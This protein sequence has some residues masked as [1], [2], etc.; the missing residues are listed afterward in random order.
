MRDIRMI[1]AIAV[2]IDGTLTDKNRVLC[3]ASLQAVRQLNVPLVLAT[4][5]THCFT[6]TMAIVLG[7]PFLFIAENGGVVCRS[8]GEMEILADLQICESAY[9]ELSK[10]FQ[11][12]RH[13]SRYRFTDIT[14]KRNFDVEAAARYIMERGIPVELIDTAF[15][16]HIKDI[17]VDKGT[18]LQ[19]I[20][21]RMGIPLKEFAAVGD[22]SSDYPMF[23]LAGFK[24]SVGNASPDLK[25]VSD[26][27][28]KAEYGEGFAE[29]AKYL[30]DKKM[31]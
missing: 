14:L 4:G 27:V 17:S 13:D 3:P 29:I 31:V 6:R 11:L 24:A 21:R 26:Y 30:V 25:A 16:V 28:A 5:N 18:G 1:R 9:L 7:T 19:L 2:D 10:V 22:S 12:Q 8:N 15:A 20:A 23:R